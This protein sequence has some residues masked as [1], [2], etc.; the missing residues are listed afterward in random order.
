[1]SQKHII[2][3]I[4]DV[5]GSPAAETIAFAL[6]GSSYEI[7]L[8]SANAAKL[9]DAMALFIGA[10]RRVARPVSGA[11]RQ[12]TVNAEKGQVAAVREWAKQNGY[13]IGEKGRIPATVLAA[14][15]AHR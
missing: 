11:K 10:G 12:K 1:M 9:R 2:Q 13:K 14:Y 3:L 7:D 8:N 5:D 6:D 4:D 15:D